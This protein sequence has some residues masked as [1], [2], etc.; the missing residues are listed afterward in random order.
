MKKA[1]SFALVA[2]VVGSSINASAQD[3]PPSSSHA[4]PAARVGFQM[5]IRTGYAVPMGSAR[6]ANPGT[7]AQDLAMSDA[8]SGQVP[9]FIEIGGKVAPALFIGGYLGL[10]FGGAAGQFDALCRQGNLN[11]VTVG[12]RIGA[13]IQYHI[14]PGEMA[15]PWIGYGIGYESVALGMSQGGQTYT[16]SLSG[17]EFAHLM[18]GIDFRVSRVFGIGPFVDFSAGTYSKYHVEAPTLGSEDGDV[19]ATTTHE[20]LAFGARGTFF[21]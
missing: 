3:A 11:C 1:L 10:G 21:P 16:D 4:P 14:L 18:G 17:I 5:A 19:Q 15:N 6:G 7:T 12:A 20:W 2:I 13:E 8:Y 9:I